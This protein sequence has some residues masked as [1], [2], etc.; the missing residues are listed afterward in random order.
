MGLLT[1]IAEA[2]HSLGKNKIRTAL[3]VLGIVIGIGA[4]IAMVAVATGAQRKVER[5]IAAIGDDWLTI[6]YMGMTRGG[7]HRDQATPKNQSRD[8]AAAIERECSAVRAASPTNR[9]FSQVISQY[10]NY[11][12]GVMGVLQAMNRDEGL[13]IVLVTHESDI[14]AYAPRQVTFRDGKIVRDTAANQE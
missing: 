6:W 8:D 1:I 14:A 11:R 2:F 13:C 10:G 12:T 9:V 4:V 3:S 5:E 7:V